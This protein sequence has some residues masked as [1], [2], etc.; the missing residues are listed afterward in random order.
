MKKNI[1]TEI[2]KSP[3]YPA[4]INTKLSINYTSV[5]FFKKC[6]FRDFPGRPVVK[7]LHFHCREYGFNPCSVN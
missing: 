7:T 4:E 3:C 6:R 5:I 1:Y 2:A